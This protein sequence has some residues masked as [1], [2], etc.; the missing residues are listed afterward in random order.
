M[1]S[2]TYNVTRPLLFLCFPRRVTPKGLL[3]HQQSSGG[4]HSPLSLML[5]HGSRPQLA[6]QAAFYHTPPVPRISLSYRHCFQSPVPSAGYPVF[7]CPFLFRNRTPQLYSFQ[8]TP[9]W[10]GQTHACLFSVLSTSQKQLRASSLCD[11]TAKQAMLPRR[12]S[13]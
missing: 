8:G 6:S 4:L 1:D 7:S 9:L 5:A 2:S 13:L 11:L 12:T 10:S 3:S